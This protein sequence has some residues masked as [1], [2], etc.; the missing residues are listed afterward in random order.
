[1]TPRLTMTCRPASVDVLRAQGAS[2][3]GKS[4]SV[5]VGADMGRMTAP[6]DATR[7]RR[8]AGSFACARQ[9]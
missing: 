6:G 8:G 7:Y 3:T 9:A 1:M 2:S 5:P 4:G